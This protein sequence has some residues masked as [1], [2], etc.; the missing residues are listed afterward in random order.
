MQR[1]AYIDPDTYEISLMAWDDL[2]AGWI[3]HVRT[4]ERWRAGTLRLYQTTDTNRFISMPGRTVWEIMTEDESYDIRAQIQHPWIP[5]GSAIELY[6]ADIDALEALMNVAADDDGSPPA[7]PG[8]GAVAAAGAES[9][10]PQSSPPSPPPTAV[11]ALAWALPENPVPGGAAAAAAAAAGAGEGTG[12]V[13]THYHTHVHPR[14]DALWAL[15][16]PA[17]LWE[18]A[19]P[20]TVAPVAPRQRSLHPQ[21]RGGRSLDILTLALAASMAPSAP[22]VAAP[23]PAPFP[24]H[25]ADMVLKKAE[26]DAATCP[27]TMEPIKATDAAVTS[28]GHVFQTGAIREWLATHATCP[29]CR[30]S[31]SV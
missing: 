3:P 8:G 17:L 30:Q 23:A 15:L 12:A 27:I 6:D 21:D 1:R 25:L 18:A 22:Q 20:W 2:W 26:A 19:D 16:R 4:M 31:C 24:K 10:S 14:D 7:P 11:A 13:H 29:E 9:Q 28:C 5:D